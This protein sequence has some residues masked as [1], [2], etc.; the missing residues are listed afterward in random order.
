M[1][2]STVRGLSR[3]LVAMDRLLAPSQ[4]ALRT[5]LSALVIRVAMAERQRGWFN[6][7]RR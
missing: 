2:L 5:L 1:W 4:S 3:R 6:I 7:P